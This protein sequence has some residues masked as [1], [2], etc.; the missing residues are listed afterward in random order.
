[1]L[2]RPFVGGLFALLDQNVEKRELRWCWFGLAYLDTGRWSLHIY[3]MVHW[4]VGGSMGRIYIIKCKTGSGLDHFP[5]NLLWFLS[6]RW[7]DD[8][9]RGLLFTSG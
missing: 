5:W 1:M 7:L 8:A 6:H 3:K 9:I 2:R 4:L